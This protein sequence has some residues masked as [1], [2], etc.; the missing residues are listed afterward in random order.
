MKTRQEYLDGAC[1]HREYYAQFVT[2]QIL[3]IV[4]ARIG[5]TDIQNSTNEHFNDIPLKQ[6]DNLPILIPNH[7]LKQT[8]EQNTLA[9]KV[10]IAKEAA[11]Q[12][13]ETPHKWM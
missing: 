13:R 1:T 6:W 9:T 4:A 5:T 10:C 8:G 2:A 7:L 3:N 11:Q 12:I